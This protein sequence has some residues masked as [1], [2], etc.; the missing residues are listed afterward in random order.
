MLPSGHYTI[1]R[2]QKAGA[3]ATWFEPK[4]RDGLLVH[5]I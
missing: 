2:Q 1:S 5:L 3:I 4:L